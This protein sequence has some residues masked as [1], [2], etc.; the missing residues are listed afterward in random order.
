[1][2]YYIN[3]SGDIR[4]VN[5]LPKKADPGTFILTGNNEQIYIR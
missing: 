1:M 3:I 2:P 4:I 5:I